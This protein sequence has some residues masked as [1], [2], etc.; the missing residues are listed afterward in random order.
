LILDAQKSSA[1]SIRGRVEGHD[2]RFAIIVSRFNALITDRLLAGARACLA[3]H[4]VGAD[5]IDVVSV[6]GAWEL[7]VAAQ[8]ATKRGYAAVIALG[9][10]I[11]GDTPHFE[12]VAGAAAHG[13]ERVSLEAG[14]PVAFGV[15]T[16]EDTHQAL[17]RAGGREGNK[18]WDAALVALEMAD[19]LDGWPDEGT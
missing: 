11:R 3:E 9:C 17:A 12:Y 4:G 14:L 18:G 15:L 13:L 6:P 16:T 5:A 1:R 10:V 19:L 2:R 8:A 7:P